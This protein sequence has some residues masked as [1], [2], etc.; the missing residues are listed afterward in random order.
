MPS[1]LTLILPAADL[2]FVDS[3]SATPSPLIFTKVFSLCLFNV[4]SLLPVNFKPS[5]KVATLSP[6]TSKRGFLSASFPSTPVPSTPVGPST[7][8]IV[9]AFAPFLPARPIEPSFPLSETEEPSL[10]LTSNEPSVPGFPS[11]DFSPSV[12]LSAVAIS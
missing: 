1:A 11:S 6:F 10:P 5:F 7:V 3:A 12:M 8:L 9:S 4:L 2:K